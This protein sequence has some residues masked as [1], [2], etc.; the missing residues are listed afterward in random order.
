MFTVI[1]QF[2]VTSELNSLAA[3]KHSNFSK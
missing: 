2:W 1:K 3:D